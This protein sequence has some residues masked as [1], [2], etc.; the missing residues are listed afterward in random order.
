MLS[1]LNSFFGKS[2]IFQVEVYHVVPVFDQKPRQF[3]FSFDL[4]SFC[5]LMYCRL[6]REIL[7]VL[8]AQLQS[9]AAVDDQDVRRD[10]P[11]P[12]RAACRVYGLDHTRT[13][14]PRSLRNGIYS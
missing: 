10:D 12:S 2:N 11:M 9:E 4:Y 14:L 3:K 6:L 13:H 8:L 5:F 7:A 1:T